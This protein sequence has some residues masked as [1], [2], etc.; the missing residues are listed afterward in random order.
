MTV[1]KQ[2]MNQANKGITSNGIGFDQNTANRLGETYGARADEIVSLSNQVR[3][4]QITQAAAMA[5]AMNDS[6]LL[7]TAQRMISDGAITF[8]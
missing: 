2:R 1:A 7:A 8:A 5:Q 4:G 6:Q 3:D